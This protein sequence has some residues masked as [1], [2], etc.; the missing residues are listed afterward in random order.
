VN[1]PAK[2]LPAK[3]RPLCPKH[4]DVHLRPEQHP[5]SQEGVVW[6]WRCDRCMSLYTPDVPGV[7]R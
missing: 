5:I 1:Q 2:F 4:K 3:D 7:P 6:Y